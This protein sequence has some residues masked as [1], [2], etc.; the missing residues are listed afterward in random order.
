MTWLRT[1]P[2][3]TCLASVEMWKSELGDG[4]LKVAA[5]ARDLLAAMKDFLLLCLPQEGL[6]FTGQGCIQWGHDMNETWDEPM[7][8]INHSHK[9]LELF[10]GSRAWQIGDGVDPEARG[11]TPDGEI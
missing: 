7:I 4:K 10:D 1:A 3:A 2:T 9:F 6:G 5:A 11:R 8:T